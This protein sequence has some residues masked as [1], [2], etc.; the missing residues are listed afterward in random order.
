ML[1]IYLMATPHDIFDL[2][3]V[4][5]LK[6]SQMKKTLMVSNFFFQSKNYI[7]VR[8]VLSYLCQLRQ[9]GLDPSL[10]V[11]AAGQAFFTISF[12]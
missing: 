11:S 10:G 7:H 5:V 2:T 9:Q 1:L 4:D 6:M 8:I 12:R 3:N